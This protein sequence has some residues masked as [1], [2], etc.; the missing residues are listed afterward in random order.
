VSAETVAEGA[1]GDAADHHVQGRVAEAVASGRRALILIRGGPGT[2]KTT[3]LDDALSTVAI[4]D[5]AAVPTVLR[6][7]CAEDAAKQPFWLGRAVVDGLGLTGPGGH[8]SPLLGSGASVIRPAL[9]AVADRTGRRFT[10][11]GRGIGGDIP[12]EPVTA[13]MPTTEYTVLSGLS[14]LVGNVMADGPFV[15]SID[16]LQWC[17]EQSLR[18]IDYLM[19][20]AR[21]KPLIV[22]ATVRTPA[23]A[24]VLGVAGDHLG[25][26]YGTMI[27]LG[28]LD[29]DN[30]R[31]MVEA[32]TGVEP[33]PEFVEACRL[34]SG[35]H[36]GT[37]AQMVAAVAAAGLEPDD[38][39]VGQLHH[40]AMTVIE[41]FVAENLAGQPEH[42]HHVVRAVAVLASTDIDLVS[43]LSG[44]P[45]RGVRASLEFLRDNHFLSEHGD[46]FR[47]ELV[48]AALLRAA[49]DGEVTWMRDRAARLLNDA[50]L[51]AEVVASQLLPLGVAPEPWMQT[52]L[53]DAARDASSRGAPKV[54]LRHLSPL[55][56]Q[57]PGDL[58]LRGQIAGIVA[59]FN[60]RQALDHLHTTLDLTT[61][62]R[63][64]AELAIE[65]G[66]CA[67][68]VQEAPAAVRV[69]TE[70]ADA[71]YATIAQAETE[72]T[73]T[74]SD[75]TDTESDGI[76]T[77][78]DGT[79]ADTEV[80]AEFVA[81][82][83][84]AYDRELCMRLEAT[85]MLVG[86]SDRTTFTLARQ[87]L[88]GVPEPVGDTPAD[89]YLMAMHA[90]ERVVA[91]TEP[92][93]AV[94]L[95]RGALPL[96]PAGYVNPTAAVAAFVFAIADELPQSLAALDLAIANDESNG[97][98]W[99]QCRTL[100]IRAHVRYASGDLTGATTD[101]RLSLELAKA[102]G[103]G[104]ESM[105]SS[106]LALA[107]A[108]I[109]L[110]ELDEARSALDSITGTGMEDSPFERHTLMLA[111]ALAR[112]ASGELDKG[113]EL[114]QQCGRGLEADGV[115]NPLFLPWWAEATLLF[116]ERGRARAALPLVEYGEDLVA[117]WDVPRAR[118]L[119]RTARAMVSRGTER[120]D[121]LT[122]AAAAMESSGALLERQR[123]VHLLGREL[124][125]REDQ[126]AAR[127]HLRTAADLASWCGATA[128]A[129]DARDLLLSAGGRM[130][131]VTGART[132][133][134]TGSEL[135]VVELAVSGA[136]NRE[137]GE[138]LFVT[139]RTVEVHL[140]N[141]YRKLGIA[142]RA[143]LP[144]ALRELT[145]NRPVDVAGK[146]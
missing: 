112:A 2:G 18:W 12:P 72:G 15:L 146:G 41:A 6:V 44:V 78:S 142:G 90:V 91:G 19:R 111:S 113:I 4:G 5:G 69:L 31:A 138:E 134:L 60:P 39:S 13:R 40:I 93:R 32:G 46:D 43:A 119:A 139:S 49:P 133:V 99:S 30:V 50:G 59:K 58:G 86:S 117:R 79:G 74:E 144:A 92:E 136:T 28:P 9:W 14:R 123:V 95:A 7:R 88:A 94:A 23:P 129:V 68:A 63:A 76:D 35:G 109:P 25:A 38:T 103:W 54:A 1:A 34:V 64:R 121:L 80:T 33:G 53:R 100:G 16:D 27:T 96:D 70:A 122:D 141:V 29:L 106:V 56:N 77:E 62:P 126:K 36:R 101:A 17:D 107:L 87:R 130:R 98:L 37:L 21:D 137:I 55:L 104:P 48:R 105:G 116:A 118:A 26:D 124:L 57:S 81:E 83:A 120:I 110:G 85:V 73:D 115:T 108:L 97:A 22:I 135:R 20:R 3:V 143:D 89:R 132:D 128:A 131:Q 65:L 24:A 8:D 51:P 47:H 127:E 10:R 71:L 52:V 75:A 114:L 66:Q 82:Q 125:R 42:V 102:E 140:T 45:V 84:S 61:D 145:E 11:P 67:S